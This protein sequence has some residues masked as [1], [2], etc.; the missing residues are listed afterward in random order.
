MHPSKPARLT[1]AIVGGGFTGGAIALHLA[2]SR[3][4]GLAIDI[5]VFEPRER[6]G[7]GLAYDTEESVHRINVPAGRMS[8]Y[9]DA[10]GHFQD[11]IERTDALKDDGEALA[12]DGLHYPRR[13]LFGRYVADHLAPWLASGA[14]WHH[15][16]R[17]ENI[18]RQGP[19]WMVSAADGLSI[20]ADIVILAA[21]HPAPGLPGVLAGL[22]NDPNLIADA[23]RPDALAS[24][25]DTDR[26]L[27][28]G[29]GLTAADV[30]AALE[31][32]G[33]TGDILSISR[34]G[35]RSRGHAPQVQEPFGDFLS[36]PAAT[37]SDLLRR[38]RVTLRAAEAEG[39]TWHS[40]LDAVRAQGQEIWQRLPVAERRRI[41]RHVR[42]FWDVHRF[43]IAPQVEAAVERAISAGRLT[44]LAAS[45]AAAG[46]DAQGIWVTLKPRRSRQTVRRHVDKVIVTTGPDHGGVLASQPFLASLARQGKVTACPTGLGI[47]CARDGRAIDAGGRVVDG[48]YVAGPLARGTFG[49]LMGLPQVSDY[50]VF[51]AAR[52][53]E[54]LA[55]WAAPDETAAAPS[56]ASA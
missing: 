40:V 7:A 55:A 8:L 2:T 51:I 53:G 49:E 4:Q 44:V 52:V 41:A 29:N 43:R 33:H 9:P 25:G 1:V 27:I 3:R 37:A 23:T 34:R 26:I 30:I 21:T 35:L 12:E 47:L 50:A 28:V 36:Q 17:V 6:L 20:E 18:Q 31:A 54:D 42:P 5:V 38:V 10:P 39:R 22:R 11:W 15:R 19:R 56:R 16:A 46:A 13:G 45:V 32:R 24:V 48:L 14:V